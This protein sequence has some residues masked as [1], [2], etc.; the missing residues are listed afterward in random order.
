MSSTLPLAGRAA[1]VTGAG[2]GIGEAIAKELASA[3]AWVLVQDLRLEAAATVADAIRAAGG[4]AGAIGGDVSNPDD[5]AAMV[6]TIKSAHGRFDILVN[7]AGFQ[8]IAPIE[9]FPLEVWNKLLGV[10]LTGP[11]LLTQAAIPIMRRHGWGRIINMSS[12]NGKQGDRGKAAYCSA[13]HGLIGLTRTAALETAAEGITVNA[14]CPGAVDTPLLRNQLDDL[15]A[16]RGVSSD[17]ALDTLF[18]GRIPQHRLIDPSEIAAMARF[19]ASDEA[20]GI[21]GQ[22]INVSAGWLMH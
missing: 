8:H 14:I 13:K 16:V 11:F 19:L 21:T 2:S 7:N 10:L 3:G 20:R 18:L 4:E 5:V 6:D 22:S 17:D 12:V 15:A 9:S 1:L